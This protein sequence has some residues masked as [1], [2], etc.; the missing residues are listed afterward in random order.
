M[1]SC[2]F[3]DISHNTFS[4]EPFGRLL[5]HKYLSYFQKQPPEVFY[6]K[7]CCE[8]FHKIHKKTFV[9]EYLI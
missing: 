5:L 8:K 4:K 2:E 6:V 1:F 3:Y 9:P 7:R